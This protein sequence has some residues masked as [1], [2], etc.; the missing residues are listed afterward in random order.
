MRGPCCCTRFKCFHRGRKWA[1]LPTWKTEKSSSSSRP[2][3]L[4]TATQHPSSG[5][6]AC[7]SPTKLRVS[8]QVERNQQTSQRESSGA[9]L[10]TWRPG[11]TCGL[12][13]SNRLLCR[14][15][16]DRMQHAGGW[17]AL[18]PQLPLDPWGLCPGSPGSSPSQH[19][20]LGTHPPGAEHLLAPPPHEG[21]EGPASTP[22]GLVC[23]A[24]QIPDFSPTP[25]QS[26]VRPG[27]EC[28]WKKAGGEAP[29]ACK[30]QL[31]PPH[32][33]GLTAAVRTTAASAQLSSHGA[34][35][36]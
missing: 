14:G 31:G 36:V 8:V 16:V 3:R 15:P 29:G 2:S 30:A 22:G 9:Q 19:A 10:S 34:A 35:R 24:T 20:G 7:R 26:L 27:S 12:I 25:E 1:A 28:N 4:H 32:G 21:W 6:S 18:P 33:Q 11:G 13:V 17:L 5:A 23:P